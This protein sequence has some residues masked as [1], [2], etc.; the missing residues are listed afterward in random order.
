MSRDHVCGGR[1]Y[2]R[3]GP[4]SG[5]GYG[6]GQG[7]NHYAY[8]SDGNPLVQEGRGQSDDKA[9]NIR[10]QVDQVVDIMQDNIDRI[11]QRGETLQDVNSKAED[12]S[13]TSQ[14]FQRSAVKV[15]KKMW[16]NN[17]KWKIIIGVC[18]IIIILVIVLS[19]VLS[20]NK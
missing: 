14:A 20:K 15:R 18:L 10:Q 16:W 17:M 19:V 7:D 5:G 9:K 8:Q 3:D 2:L 6:G 4:G 12:L 13:V 11:H 1:S